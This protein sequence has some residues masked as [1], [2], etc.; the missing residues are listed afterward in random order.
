MLKNKM[1]RTMKIN[2]IMNFTSED[3][4]PIIISINQGEVITEYLMEWAKSDKA[5]RI[6]KALK[7]NPLTGKF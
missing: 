1:L 3:G 4:Q 7:A 2:D 5:M 6:L